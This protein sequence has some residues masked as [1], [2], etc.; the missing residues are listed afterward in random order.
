MTIYKSQPPSQVMTSILYGLRTYLPPYHSTPS[1]TESLTF[2]PNLA[3]TSKMP[4]TKKPPRHTEAVV[5]TILYFRIL[6]VDV[7]VVAKLVEL[8]HGTAV[9][10]G[11][12]EECLAFHALKLSQQDLSWTPAGVGRYIAGITTRD[13]FNTITVIDGECEKVLGKAS[14]IARKSWITWADRHF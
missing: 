12:C 3:R 4:S 10:P 2:T 13:I 7:K 14:H 5:A 8:K 11:T 1:Q 6:G 9:S